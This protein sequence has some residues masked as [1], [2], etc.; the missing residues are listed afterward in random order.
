MQK[1]KYWYNLITIYAFKLQNTA[2][3]FS[4]FC[5]SGP[6]T[7]TYSIHDLVFVDFVMYT[8]PVCQGTDCG[9]HSVD[10]SCARLLVLLTLLCKV[11]N[12]HWTEILIGKECWVMGWVVSLELDSFIKQLEPCT[13]IIVSCRI[14]S[15]SIDSIFVKQWHSFLSKN[16][17]SLTS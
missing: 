3:M 8:L 7:S 17:S 14:M 12:S 1:L 5:I 11:G 4:L 15:D 13:N 10:S 2:C 9:G 6:C 16:A